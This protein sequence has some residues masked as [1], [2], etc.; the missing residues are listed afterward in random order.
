MEPKLLEPIVCIVC[1]GGFGTERKWSIGNKYQRNDF[2]IVDAINAVL[3]SIDNIISAIDEK[4]QE[5]KICL[6]CVKEICK[7][8]KPF[9]DLK[10]RIHKDSHVHSKLKA[11]QPTPSPK[12]MVVYPKL[13][14]PDKKKVAQMMDSSKKRAVFCN[15]IRKILSDEVKELSTNENLTRIRRDRDGYMASNPQFRNEMKYFAPVTLACIEGMLEG[16][17][18]N[19][20]FTSEMRSV[21]GISMKS[22]NLFANGFQKAVGLT[23]FLGKASVEVL[24]FV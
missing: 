12:R 11:E 6:S 10:S 7:A 24:M 16:K 18:K 20:T 21:V 1:N 4:G 17:K 8:Y 3:F 2:T 5:R 9:N 23:L 13:V 15:Q 14:T 19:Y 22:R